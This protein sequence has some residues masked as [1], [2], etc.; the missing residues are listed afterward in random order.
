MTVYKCFIG[1]L[2]AQTGVMLSFNLSVSPDSTVGGMEVLTVNVGADLGESVYFDVSPDDNTYTQSYITVASTSLS[3]AVQDGTNDTRIL[4]GETL[5]L[6]YNLS[7]AGPSVS[8]GARVVFLLP[9]GFTYTSNTGF[10][11]CT[12]SNLDSAQITC[13]ASQ[14]IEPNTF[15]NGVISVRASSSLA[16]G[17]YPLNTTYYDNDGSIY[18][19]VKQ[20]SLLHNFNLTQLANMTLSV[21]RY[22]DSAYAGESIEYLLSLT[23]QG[24]SFFQKHLF[25]NFINAK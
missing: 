11:V 10:F 18:P 19:P 15:I 7:N 22:T 6:S 20:Q 12:A 24:D 4:A 1:N 9:T 5:S 25:P 21:S 2:S 14:S 13:A 16:V 23:N 8:N 17:I 3:L